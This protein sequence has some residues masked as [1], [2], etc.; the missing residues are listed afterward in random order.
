LFF[1][2]SDIGNQGETRSRSIPFKHRLPSPIPP[3]YIGRTPYGEVQYSVRKSTVVFASH[4]KKTFSDTQST[5]SH[6]GSCNAEEEMGKWL[7]W[8]QRN[9][10]FQCRNSERANSTSF[11]K[12]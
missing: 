10:T 5:L 6:K 11:G 2:Y 1:K 7:G 12:L 8:D 9:K 4:D 3:S